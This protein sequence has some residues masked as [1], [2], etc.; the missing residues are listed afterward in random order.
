MRPAG[1]IP[2]TEYR[3]NARCIRTI[4][5]E[6]TANQYVQY[7]VHMMK[8]I[9]YTRVREKLADT[10][11]KVCEDHDPVIITKRRDKAVVMISLEDYESLVET[12]YLLKSPRNARRLL[13]SIQQLESGKGKKKKLAS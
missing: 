1:P 4:A 10:I 8:A 11:S 3:R 6:L 2:V 5:E 9:T 12:S 7:I 13:E